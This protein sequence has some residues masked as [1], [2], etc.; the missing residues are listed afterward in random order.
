MW[1]IEYY[2]EK[3]KDEYLYIKGIRYKHTLF[4]DI[5]LKEFSP[6]FI[7]SAGR[8]GTTL[9]RKLLMQGGTVHIPPESDLNIPYLVKSYI[10]SIKTNNWKSLVNNSIELFTSS[11]PFLYWK[12]DLYK[13]ISTLLNLPEE[14]KNLYSIIDYIYNEHRIKYNPNSIIWGDKTPYLIF[15][16][17]W[18]LLLYPNCKIIH[19]IRDGR[20]VMSSYQRMTNWSLDYSTKRWIDSIRAIDKLNLSSNHLLEIKY[21]DL[22][23]NSKNTILKICEFLNI[24]YTEEIFKVKELNLGDD[25]LQHHRGIKENIY[26]KSIGRWK[27]DFTL[28]DKKYIQSELETLLIRK[29]YIIEDF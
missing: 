16:L 8:S 25:I 15:E 17:K 20:D 3:I 19:M 4:S 12:I 7:V 23:L 10:R 11:S 29:G 13:N 9:L 28:S 24:P 22:I 6:F 18:L 26:D 27:K 2:K 1:E 21:E 14:R 5:Q